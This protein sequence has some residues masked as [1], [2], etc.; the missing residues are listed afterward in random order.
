MRGTPWP[1]AGGA[2]GTHP[3]YDIVRLGGG[4]YGLGRC[5]NNSGACAN[6]ARPRR[7]HA[8]GEWLHHRCTIRVSPT[9]SEF[10]A[11]PMEGAGNRSEQDR[12]G[13]AA[14]VAVRP[15]PGCC[16]RRHRPPVQPDHG[17]DRQR[18]GRGRKGFD[19]RLRDVRGA[20][21]GR[22]HGPQ[23]EHRRGYGH[24]G[25]EAPRLQAG[26]GLERPD[27][28]EDIPPGRFLR[29]G[30]VPGTSVTLGTHDAAPPATGRGAAFVCGA[31]LGGSPLKPMHRRLRMG[32]QGEPDIKKVCVCFLRV[33]G[34]SW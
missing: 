11:H 14:R 33:A 6:G 34:V 16:R 26:Q 19:W 7:T 12:I 21:S 22:S 17:C 9:H 2:G 13:Q 3:C 23:S 24:P 8:S 4:C 31:P 32:E 20:A 28:L 25:Q 30:V 29:G 10:G 1:N 18:A 5:A 15:H 27:L